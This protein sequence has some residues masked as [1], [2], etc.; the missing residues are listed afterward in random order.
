M[1]APSTDLAA[2]PARY[3]AAW[4]QR[5]LSTALAVIAE[6][7]DWRD[8]SLPAPLTDRDGAAD[9]FTSAWSGFPDMAFHAIGEPLVDAANNR[10]T[11]EWRM[12]GTHTGEGF[13]PGVPPTGRAF[14]V[15]GMD[16]WQVDDAG[17]AVSVH[18]YWNVMTL[19]AQLGLV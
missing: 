1:T 8:P 6:R 17:R 7:V 13:P 14:D 4:S 10:V 5:D 11:Q 18:A 16:V 19:L 9:F 12:T 2:Y 3:F 15:T